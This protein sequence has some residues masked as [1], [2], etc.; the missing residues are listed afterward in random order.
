MQT[1]LWSGTQSCG[2]MQYLVVVQRCLIN[3]VVSEERAR[4][5]STA[6]VWSYTNCLLLRKKSISFA[7]KPS[8]MPPLRASTEAE[9]TLTPPR[10]S[11]WLQQPSGWST[12]RSLILPLHSWFTSAWHPVRSVVASPPSVPRLQLFVL[13]LPSFICFLSLSIKDFKASKGPRPETLTSVAWWRS[14]RHCVLFLS[15]S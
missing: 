14:L 2:Q 8:Q 7:L 5:C 13:L 10:S 11:A 15:T 12:C 9:P 3:G 6:C 4:P 1:S